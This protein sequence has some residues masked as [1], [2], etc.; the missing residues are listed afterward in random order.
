LE[1]TQ[2]VVLYLPHSSSS[3]LVLQVMIAGLVVIM[4]TC[5]RSGIGAQAPFWSSPKGFHDWADQLRDLLG[6]L[7]SCQP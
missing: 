5:H 6:Y 4:S 3:L 2:G 7:H 1:A